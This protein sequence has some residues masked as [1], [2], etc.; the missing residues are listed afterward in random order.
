MQVNFKDSK[1]Y[2]IAYHALHY[3]ARVAFFFNVIISKN[4]NLLCKHTIAWNES[5]SGWSVSQNV[6]NDLWFILLDEIFWGWQCEI[7]SVI[8]MWAALQ[9]EHQSHSKVTP[10]LSSP[11]ANPQPPRAVLYWLRSHDTDQ[12]VA[13]PPGWVTS[14]TSCFPPAAKLHFLLLVFVLKWRLTAQLSRQP[15]RWRLDL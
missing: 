15:R 14:L 12:P 8:C 1:P 2:F 4:S 5:F 7:Y 10:P 6:L 13:C 9:T 11:P 3:L